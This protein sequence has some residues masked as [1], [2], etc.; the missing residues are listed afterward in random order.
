MLASGIPIAQVLFAGG[1][2]G[3]VVLPL[4]VFHQIQLIVC[5]VIARRYA[6]GWDRLAAADAPPAGAQSRS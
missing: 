1:A 6:V 3:S 2:L 5:A 4:M